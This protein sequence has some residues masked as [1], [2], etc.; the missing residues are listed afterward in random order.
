VRFWSI[1]NEVK[2]EITF[3]LVMG[4]DMPFV[5]GCYRLEDGVWHVFT[6]FKSR[7]HCEV[8]VRTNVSWASGVTG[9]NV[10][11]ADNAKLNRGIVLATLSRTLS[12]TEWQ[13]V[14]GPDSM[15]LR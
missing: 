10:I 14:R 15:Q 7:G 4:D 11:V 6:C 5:E 9:V 12:V 8:G 13:E 3:D 1:A 2:G